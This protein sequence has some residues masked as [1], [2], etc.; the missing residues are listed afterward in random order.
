MP[1][2]TITTPWRTCMRISLRSTT[3]AISPPKP[4]R[5]IGWR[6][7][8][9]RPVVDRVIDEFAGDGKAELYSQLARRAPIRVISRI[10]G[11]PWQDDAWVDQC[12]D[13]MNALS[14][15]F[16]NV[17]DPQLLEGALGAARALIDLGAKLSEI[18]DLEDRLSAL[19]R[20]AGEKGRVRGR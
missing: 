12:R 2:P 14:T 6:S 8:L 5:N 1:P 19:E 17:D 16:N 4:L 15:F 10:M 18:L 11:L 13:Q 20:Q 7:T 3:A 9:I